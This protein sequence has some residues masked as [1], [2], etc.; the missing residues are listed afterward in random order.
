[1]KHLSLAIILTLSL[2]KPTT[3]ASQE[4]EIALAV[5]AAFAIGGAIASVNQA[6]EQL[7]LKATQWILGNM[8]IKKFNVK[9]MS[10]GWN[11]FKDASNS[12]LVPFQI[13]EY[14]INTLGDG[15]QEFTILNRYILMMYSF[16]GFISENGIDYTDVFFE[17]MDKELWLKRMSEYV[18]SASD[19][20]LDVDSSVESGMIVNKGVTE[21]LKF[22]NGAPYGRNYNGKYLKIKFYKLDGD[23]YI[24]SDYVDEFKYL[25]NEKALGMFHIKTNRLFQVRSKSIM[26]IHEFLLRKTP[27]T[28]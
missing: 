19:T 10:L 24:V 25:Y 14:E 13:F 22:K 28:L 18:K 3:S 26:E 1:M 27:I 15:K 5:G 21:G 16:P 6:E 20:N 7:E 12:S 11:S 9:V 2:F 8:D 17:L 4:N 23:S